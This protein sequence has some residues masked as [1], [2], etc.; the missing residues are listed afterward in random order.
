MPSA[1]LRAGA[2][3]RLFRFPDGETKR[4]A[5]SR[6][7]R[8]WRGST[9][10]ADIDQHELLYTASSLRTHASETTTTLG[11]TRSSDAASSSVALHAIRYFD[12]NSGRAADGYHLARVVHGDPGSLSV[13]AAASYRD[14]EESR[15]AAGN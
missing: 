7:A 11:W 5:A 12:G 13:G 4:S 14:T 6:S 15:S 1:H 9:I 10:S 2:S 8:E 3:L